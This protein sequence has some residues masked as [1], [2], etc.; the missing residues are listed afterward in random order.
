MRIVLISIFLISALWAEEKK[1]PREQLEPLFQSTLDLY[2]KLLRTENGMYLDAYQ[3]QKGKNVDRR[4]ST[5]AVGVGLIALCME[6]E[7]GRD[8]EAK[9]KS[10][11]TLRAINGKKPG[12]Q[13]DR[14]KAGYY[15]HFFQ[16]DSGQGKSEHSTIDTAIMVVGALFCRNIFDDPLIKKEADELWSSID[17]EL[18]LANPSGRKLHMVIEDGRPKAKTVTSLFNEYYLLAALIREAQI[19]KTGKSEVVKFAQLPTWENEG[20]VILSDWRKVPHCSF[21]IQFPFYLSHEGASDPAFA[22]FVR[23]QAIADQKASSRWSGVPHYWGNG[24]GMMPVGGYRANVYSENPE[25]VISPHIIGGFISTNP[26]ALGHLLKLY[27]DPKRTVDSLVGKILPRFSVKHS[28]W[29]A[30]RVEAIDYS[31]MLFGLAASHS[32]LGMV[33][34][35]KGTRFSFLVKGAER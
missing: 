33:F 12:F 34:F 13:I 21:L 19:Q 10:L 1:T 7:L 35:R 5:A 3:F 23:A 26:D 29:W 24:A 18:A 8:P 27:Q 11:E 15:R 17:W 4:C 16:S 14:E 22:K 32:E 25:Q 28:G 9:R 30:P 20:E 2:G 31:S 6:H